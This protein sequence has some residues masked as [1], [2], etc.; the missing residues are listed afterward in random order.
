MGL[1]L[2]VAEAGRFFIFGGDGGTRSGAIALS[3]GKKAHLVVLDEIKSNDEYDGVYRTRVRDPCATNA[4]KKKRH[5]PIERR[6]R[7]EDAFRT[8]PLGTWHSYCRGKQ[9][10]V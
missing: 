4:K 1:A 10:E 8:H 5:L 3:D 2:D 6:R 7:R 9:H